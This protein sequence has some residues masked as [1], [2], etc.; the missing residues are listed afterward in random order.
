M[1]VTTLVNNCD[2]NNLCENLIDRDSI[3]PEQN[4]KK[5]ENK[6]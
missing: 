5:T 4:D 6:N 3:R 2:Q 1:G